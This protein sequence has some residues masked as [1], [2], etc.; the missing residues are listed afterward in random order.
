M[1]AQRRHQLS[2]GASSAAL[3]AGETA[4]V[5]APVAAAR[6]VDGSM[7]DSASDA[8][9]ARLNQAVAEL[10]AMT[11]APLL[12]R[13]VEAIGADDNKLA[14]EL[15]LKALDHDERNGLAWYL[16]AIAREQAGDFKGSIAC[17][18]S[19]LSL[20]ENHADI[21]NDL[22]RLAYRVGMKDVAAKLFAHYHAAYPDCAQG[23][24]NLACALRDMNQYE[25]AIEVLKPA[26]MA[27]PESTAL[28]NT[29]GTILSE[30]GEP[31]T[32]L[33]FF[34]EALR[35]DPA[36]AKARYNRANG[37]LDIGDITGAMDDCEG[38]M[39]G[40]ITAPDLAM[41]NLARST[42][43]L[44]QGRIGEGWDAYEVRQDPE[45]VDVTHFMIDRPRWTPDSPMLGQRML[46]MGEQGLGDEVLFAGI[47]PDV[48]KALGPDGHLS[49]A[50]EK[51]L[52]S[53]FARSFPTAIIGA[54]QTYKVDSHTV[55]G[56]PFVKDQSQIDVW[57]PMASPLRRFRRSVE[58][59]G[60]Q[61][62][63]LVA[64]PERVAHWREQL[65]DLP[66]LKVGVL[67]KSLKL[68]GSRLRHFSPFDQ[69]RVVL[70]TPGVSFVN[71]Q[72]GDCEAELTEARDGL[73]LDIRQ[74][75]GI[76]LKEDLDDVAALCGAMDL[77][78]GPANATTNIAA[79]CGAPVWLISTPAA[80]P[81]LGTDRYPW[82]PQVRV[83]SPP[84]F[85]EWAPVMDEVARVLVAET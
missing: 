4:G 58:D 81:R 64:D 56:A 50:V 59:F 36:F 63:Y 34:D 70:E 20:T 6:M 27:N 68:H 24:N 82:Y 7:G 31:A 54:H 1:S 67:W 12:R 72:Y 47:V 10:K 52:I 30:Q 77:I 85:N 39:S 14:S 60:R 49:I 37:K 11:I 84:A 32:A 55:R 65:A 19:A 71:L 25:D 75:E 41:M 78:I 79:A 28:W 2:L 26:I 53:L 40:A 83:F 9:L 74:P 3:A 45:F 5:K 46:M 35:L 66:G 76:D 62:S 15:A 16:L 23:A 13:A 33:T 48:L 22:G 17:Y 8:A 38:A 29:L 42:M 73:G 44:C 61:P 57:T 80:W 51:R 69:W 18:E 43:L 21:A